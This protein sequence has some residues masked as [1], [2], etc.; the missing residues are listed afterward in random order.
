MIDS[1]LNIDFTLCQSWFS[2]YGPIISDV[3]CVLMSVIDG[4][5]GINEMFRVCCRSRTNFFKACSF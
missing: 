1:E 3:F 4:E 2:G 5:G